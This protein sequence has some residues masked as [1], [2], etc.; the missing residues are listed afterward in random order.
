MPFGLTNAPST[1]QSLMNHVFR[2]HLRKF[3]LVFFDDILVF[4]KD[5][6]THLIHLETTLAILRHHKLF[7]KKSKY[8]FGCKEVDY[9]GHIVS[10]LGVKADPEKI[11]AM[12]DWPFPT[13]IKSLR[14]ILGLTGYYGKFIKGYGSIAAPLT[15]MLRKNAFQWTEGAK[16]AFQQLKA[17]VTHAQV[18]ALPNFCQ[19]FV[20][21]CDASGLGIGAVLMQAHR[22][23]AFL[24]K[25]LKGRA[26][27]MS[28]YEKELF[29]LVTAIQKWRPYL[30]G[31][32]FIVK[33][34]QQSLKFLLDKKWEPPSNRNGLQSC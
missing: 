27:H 6:S 1:F 16:D 24:S 17:A 34:D 14:G 26:L 12:I 8:R 20:I 2:P 10:E 9:L 5:F 19:P 4:S 33:T 13:T 18:L 7:G 32:T 31:Q 15:D 29:A 21:E 25:A 22:P 30:L 23:I 11:Q 28:T 3:I